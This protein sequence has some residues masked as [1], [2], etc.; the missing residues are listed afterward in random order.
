MN[1]ILAGSSFFLVLIVSWLVVQPFFAEPTVP[2]GE[3]ERERLFLAKE[4]ALELLEE[5]ENDFRSQKLDEASYQKQ[6]AELLGRAAAAMSRL[7]L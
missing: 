3:S 5:L 4:Q 1:A 7:D 6:K 2:E